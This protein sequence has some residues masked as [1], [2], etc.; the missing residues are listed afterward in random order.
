MIERDIHVST[1]MYLSC[2]LG[3]RTYLEAELDV[4]ARVS[5]ARAASSR[6][7]LAKGSER[8][9]ERFAVSQKY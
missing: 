4:P 6:F 9:K 5:R 1:R 8:R 7:R 3:N 2:P